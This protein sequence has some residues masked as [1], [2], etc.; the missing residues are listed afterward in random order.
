MPASKLEGRRVFKLLKGKGPGK[1]DLVEALFG[2]VR[3]LPDGTQVLPGLTFEAR[4]ELRPR[5]T[6]LLFT[7]TV[8]SIGTG[9][10]TGGR[11]DYFGIQGACT[12]VEDG[13]KIKG[14]VRVRY[15]L[16]DRTGLILFDLE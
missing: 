13:V 1:W 14:K 2:T 4:E 9:R 8:N 5:M 3:V 10:F 7:V 12:F 11:K 15:E 16:D 6:P